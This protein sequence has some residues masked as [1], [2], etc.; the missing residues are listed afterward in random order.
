MSEHATLHWRGGQGTS[1]QFETRF[2]D[3]DILYDSGDG[4]VAVNPARH[5]LGALAACEAMDVISILRKKRLEVTAYEVAM[6]GE[7]ASTHPRRY[8]SIELVHRVTGRGVPE[9]AVAEAVRLSEEKY[10]SV[11]HTLDPTMRLTSRIEV[12]EG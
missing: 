6:A 11:R 4:A 8:L 5:L 12:V 2:G 3:H 1:L 10:C 9:A 7:R